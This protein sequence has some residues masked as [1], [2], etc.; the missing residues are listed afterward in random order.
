[1][2]VPSLP[3]SVF[4][5]ACVSDSKLVDQVLVADEFKFRHIIFGQIYGTIYL[6]FNVGWYYLAP[7]EE[8]L[9]YAILD[10]ENKP[11]VACIYCLGCILILAPLFAVVHLG[12]YRCRNKPFV[13]TPFLPTEV[14][15]TGILERKPTACLYLSYA[16]G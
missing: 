6:A 5:D 1:M 10:W 12:V 11:L 13:L 4:F 7:R 8:R 3:A 15:L 9:I 16:L 2:K 14:Y